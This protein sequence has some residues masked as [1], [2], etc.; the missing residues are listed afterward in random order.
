MLVKVLDDYSGAK[1]D[2]KPLSNP[3]AQYGA[4]AWNRAH[5]DLAQATRTITRA[6]VSFITDPATDPNPANTQHRSVWGTSAV[7]KPVVTRTGVGLYLAT[8]ATSFDDGLGLP[9]SIESVAFAFPPLL[10]L[11]VASG[12]DM[13]VFPTGFTANTFSMAVKRFSAGSWILADQ[14]SGG[15]NVTV[16]GAIV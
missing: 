15:G 5:E 11:V 10:S 6:I 12:E 4:D 3:T 9:D 2:A 16:Y 7:Q 8:Y 13:R 14:D 1:V